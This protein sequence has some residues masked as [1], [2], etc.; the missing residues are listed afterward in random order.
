MLFNFGDEKES[1]RFKLE[2]QE[3]TIAWQSGG[4]ERFWGPKKLA[5]E[6]RKLRKEITAKKI[7]KEEAG[8]RLKG[9]G[10]TWEEGKEL[11]EWANRE[12]AAIDENKKDR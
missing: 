10:I 7:S 1:G 3:L 9:F 6:F 8:D 5:T 2:D 4:V 12:N 11:L